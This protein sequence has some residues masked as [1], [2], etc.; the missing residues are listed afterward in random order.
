MN[1]YSAVKK[2]FSTQAE[3]FA[4]YHRYITSWVDDYSMFDEETDC[5]KVDYK[6]IA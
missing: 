4:T 3:R 5:E 2:S 1:N 6:T